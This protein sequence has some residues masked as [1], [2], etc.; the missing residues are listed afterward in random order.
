[1]ASEVQPGGSN[2][3]LCLDHLDPDPDHPDQDHADSDHLPEPASDPDCD[4]HLASASDCEDDAGHDL[5]LADPGQHASFAR[6]LLAR[7]GA[8]RWC[9]CHPG[10]EAVTASAAVATARPAAAAA[11]AVGRISDCAQTHFPAV[12]LSWAQL[13]HTWNADSA[14]HQT[15][16]D[17][18]GSAQLPAW[19]QTRPQLAVCHQIHPQLADDNSIGPHPSCSNSAAASAY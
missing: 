16:S 4:S 10:P 9:V 7:I 3:L 18:A 19:D 12:T 5:T 14:V 13:S 17:A 8:V 2:L 11:A 15:C 6:L 1:M